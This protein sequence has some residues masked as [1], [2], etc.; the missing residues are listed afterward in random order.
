LAVAHDL[1]NFAAFLQER[2]PSARLVRADDWWEH[3]GLHFEKGPTDFHTLFQ[4]VGTPRS[5]LTSM[6]GDHRVFVGIGNADR[7][8]YLR[9]FADWEDEG[10]TL[11]GEYSLTLSTGLTPHFEITVVPT[12]DCS[13]ERD[14]SL[15]YF[16][17]IRA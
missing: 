2:D 13:L 1:C 6:P 8:W 12:L 5:L 17:R 10:E 14:D 3:D 16:E 15:A 11:L 4:I 9:F 7:S